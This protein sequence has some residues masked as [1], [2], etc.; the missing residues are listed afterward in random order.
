MDVTKLS[1]GENPQKVTAVI[2]IPYGSNIKYELDKESGAIAVDRVMFSSVFYPANYGF[3]PETLAD[4]GDP[5]DILV[6]GD[7][8]IAPG[9]TI[10]CRLIGMLVMEDES[11]QDEKLIAVPCSKIDPQFDRVEKLDDLPEIT[12]KRIKNFFETYKILE[13]GKWVKVKDFKGLDEAKAMLD[14]AINAYKG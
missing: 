3:V 2:E 14:K 11:G 4:D 1:A 9:A 6:L 8:A 10:K 7:Y 5:S 13:P 12:L